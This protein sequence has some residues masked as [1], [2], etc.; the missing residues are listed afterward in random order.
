MLK[1]FSVENLDRNIFSIQFTSF[2]VY[3]ILNLKL[4]VCLGLEYI[5]SSRLNLNYSRIKIFH[6]SNNET[7]IKFQLSFV[8][9]F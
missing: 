6:E 3:T 2:N 7:P 5:R 8:Q 9:N 4:H 1:L